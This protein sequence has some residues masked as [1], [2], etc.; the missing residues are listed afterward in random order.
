MNLKYMPE[1]DTIYIYLDS[2]T[3]KILIPFEGDERIGKFVDKASRK[4]T[5][6]Y[7]I[8]GAKENLLN[9]LVKLDLSLKQILAIGVYFIRI[10]NGLTQEEMASEIQV[11]LS[12]YKNLEKAEQNISIDTVELINKKYPKVRKVIGQSLLA[13]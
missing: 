7:E 12:T 10:S 13:S 6:G 3:A 2:K 11:S 8:E 5:C 9:S 1:I 4:K